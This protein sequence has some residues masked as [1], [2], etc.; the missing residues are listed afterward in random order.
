MAVQARMIGSAFD[1]SKATSPVF[2]KLAS[3]MPVS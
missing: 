1:S 3:K 2:L